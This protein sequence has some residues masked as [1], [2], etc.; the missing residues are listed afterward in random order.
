M[1]ELLLGI[2]TQLLAVPSA[3]LIIR[4]WTRSKRTV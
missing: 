1:K 2:I 3:N 4:L